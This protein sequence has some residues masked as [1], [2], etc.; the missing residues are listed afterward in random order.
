MHFCEICAHLFVDPW[1]YI[2]RKNPPNTL[3]SFL[4]HPHKEEIPSPKKASLSPLA[5]L[6][7]CK[8]YKKL[9]LTGRYRYVTISILSHGRVTT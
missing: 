4:L 6:L 2:Y 7:F 1:Y 8:I 3:Y 9:Y 5:F